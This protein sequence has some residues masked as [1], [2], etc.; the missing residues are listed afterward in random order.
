MTTKPGPD[1]ED[2]LIGSIRRIP[3][4]AWGNALFADAL[5]GFLAFRKRSQT[6]IRDLQSVT[7]TFAFAVANNLVKDE[8]G[9]VM[10]E[11]AAK[12][13][14]PMT[15]DIGKD[16]LLQASRFLFDNPSISRREIDMLVAKYSFKTLDKCLSQPLAFE[17]AARAHLQPTNSNWVVEDEWDQTCYYARGLSILLIALAHVVDL[18]DCE[19]LMF[20]GVAFRAMSEHT[21]AQ[22]LDDWNGKDALRIS[23][24]VWLRA[25]AVPL[26]S[27]R[28]YV[29]NL[30]WDRTCLISNKGWSAWIPTF[31]ASDPAYVS[32]GSVRIGR[33][34][35]CRNGV[36]KSSIW[37]N[38]H[39]SLQFMTDPRKVESYGQTI[40]LRCV[41]KVTLD[42]P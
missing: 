12:L 8:T 35:P 34:S 21:L 19:E 32:A 20:A 23:D 25:V 16:H 31:E 10:D 42:T 3:A 14:T 5:Y 24:D 41:E 29:W 38:A 6:V 30:P 39:G 36:W 17:A 4:R 15:Y 13:P 11:D 9:R 1:R 7:T 33:E 26:L 2:G 18:E 22:Q 28:G 27:H 40:S 37:D